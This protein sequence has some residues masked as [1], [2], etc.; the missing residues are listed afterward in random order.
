MALV[1]SSARSDE[2]GSGV[3]LA[4]CR[5]PTISENTDLARVATL[6]HGGPPLGNRS[7][8]VNPGLKPLFARISQHRADRDP[9][10]QKRHQPCRT[11][12]CHAAL[13]FRTSANHGAGK[14]VAPGAILSAYS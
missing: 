13:R 9:G 7:G 2:P 4:S 12:P 14:P 5:A 11:S 6:S 10:R 3:A 1:S 8:R